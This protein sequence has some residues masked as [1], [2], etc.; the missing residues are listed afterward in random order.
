MALIRVGPTLRRIAEHTYQRSAKAIANNE[1]DG[2]ECQM[3][4][5]RLAGFLQGA[6]AGPRTWLRLQE[7][8]KTLGDGSYD[9][10]LGG[11]TADS[12]GEGVDPSAFE[13]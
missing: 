2:A 4:W 10:E 7:I 13:K 9:A 6:M 5:Y 1:S 8:S 11:G 12:T 3:W